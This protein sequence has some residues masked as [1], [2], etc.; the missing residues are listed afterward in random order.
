MARPP[1]MTSLPG[2]FPTEST[3]QVSEFGAQAYCK[4]RHLPSS[5]Q[6]RGLRFIDSR[7]RAQQI[8]EARSI[9][10]HMPTGLREDIHLEG[11]PEH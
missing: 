8:I 11:A 9:L 5:V 7:H 1:G 6:H 3:A 2:T 4:D 10:A